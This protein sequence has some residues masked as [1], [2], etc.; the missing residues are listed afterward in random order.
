MKG[1]T[2]VTK[3]LASALTNGVG[4]WL[5]A[6][7]AAVAILGTLATVACG[8]QASAPSDASASTESD[9]APFDLCDAFS[10][11]GTSC[12]LPGPFEC[13]PIC[14]GGCSCTATADGARWTCATD[15]SCLSACAP[16]DALDGACV[17]SDATMSA[18]GS[19]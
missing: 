13:F 8:N 19:E 16:I 11:V 18:T 17:E 3:E 6:A 5:L 10:G 4:A 1:K 7:T 15:L 9:A 12:P 2:G 14:D